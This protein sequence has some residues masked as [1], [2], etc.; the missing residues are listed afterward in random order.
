MDAAL[1][2]IYGTVAGGVIAAVPALLGSRWSR[3]QFRDQLRAQ[4][5]QSDLAVRSAHL[6]QRREPRGKAYA[7]FSGEVLALEQAMGKLFTDF[8]GDLQYGGERPELQSINAGLDRVASLWARVVI[9]GPES[10]VAP[11]EQ[12]RKKLARARDHL[13][14]T[15]AMTETRVDRYVGDHGR[16]PFDTEDLDEISTLLQSFMDAARFALDVDGTAGTARV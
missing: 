7:E 10:V 4:Q 8:L 5:E 14:R 6:Q 12:L 15:L 9:E 16:M 11:A 1:A 13:A 2:G 3:Q